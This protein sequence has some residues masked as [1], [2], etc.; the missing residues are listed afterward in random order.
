MKKQKKPNIRKII[1]DLNMCIQHRFQL[2]HYVTELERE[3]KI[4]NDKV[5]L[6]TIFAR[7]SQK[8]S[9]AFEE[10]KNKQ[11]IVLPS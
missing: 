10:A 3:I 5:D 8:A 11:E 2:S 7:A 4:L 1:V 9:K 6:D